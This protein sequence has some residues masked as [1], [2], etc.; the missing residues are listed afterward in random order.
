LR[1][2]TKPI[3]KRRKREFSRGGAPV[4]AWFKDPVGNILPVPRAEIAEKAEF[5]LVDAQKTT[6]KKETT[7]HVTTNA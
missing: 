4:M 2:I 6:E 7:I 5:Q 1:S 3:S